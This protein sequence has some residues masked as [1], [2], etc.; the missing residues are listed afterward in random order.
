MLLLRFSRKMLIRLSLKKR[1][2]NKIIMMDLNL[3]LSVTYAIQ[4]LLSLSHFLVITHFAWSAYVL[5]FNRSVSVRFAGKY[6]LI[7]SSWLSIY[8]SKRRLSR[9]LR[10]NTKS[11]SRSSELRIT[12]L[13]IGLT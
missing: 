1:E 10:K 6:L 13:A 2:N 9:P 3:K 12:S 4:L 8:S 11:S 7:T 5:S